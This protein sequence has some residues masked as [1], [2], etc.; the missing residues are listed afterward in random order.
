MKTV[1]SKSNPKVSA[2][3]KSETSVIN[4]SK[5][6]MEYRREALKK[7]LRYLSEDQ[8]GEKWVS[9]LIDFR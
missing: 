4:Q 6:N 2:K 9:L 5:K 3:V 8:S 1:T 7:I